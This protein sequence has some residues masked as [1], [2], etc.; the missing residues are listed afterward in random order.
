[1]PKFIAAIHSRGHCKPRYF[2]NPFAW[3]GPRQSFSVEIT[4]IALV[5]RSILSHT[6]QYR[7]V[8]NRHENKWSYFI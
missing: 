1:M 5:T 3:N 6:L 8:I 4:E 2:L 7:S